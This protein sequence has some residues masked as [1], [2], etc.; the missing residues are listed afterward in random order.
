MKTTG[1]MID[2]ENAACC[3]ADEIPAVIKKVHEMIHVENI[4]IF[5]LILLYTYLTTRSQ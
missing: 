5:P 3:N 2:K 4:D 1:K